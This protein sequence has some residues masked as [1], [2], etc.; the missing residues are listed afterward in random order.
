MEKEHSTAEILVPGVSCGEVDVLGAEVQ[1]ELLESRGKQVSG[2][3]L[4]PTET[5]SI[6]V[7]IF[8]AVP[9]LSIEEQWKVCWHPHKQKQ[10]VNF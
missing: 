9:Q 8:S 5:E 6:L 7:P 3:L 2:G 1:L 4:R 10:I